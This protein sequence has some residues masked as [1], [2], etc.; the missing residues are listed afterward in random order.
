MLPDP[1]T[2]NDARAIAHGGLQSAEGVVRSR[3]PAAAEERTKPYLD[4][5][6]GTLRALADIL[7]RAPI[8]E[9]LDT[10]YT[11]VTLT[12]HIARTIGR[13]L[14]EIAEELKP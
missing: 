8:V 6:P 2:A 7:E 5:A 10:E 3:S 13:M 1:L 14:R 11:Y 12:T 4:D 9:G